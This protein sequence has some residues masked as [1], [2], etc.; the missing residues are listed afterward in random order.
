VNNKSSSDIW[1]ISKG[2]FSDVNFNKIPGIHIKGPVMEYDIS[3]FGKYML[4]P[5]PVYIE[6]RLVGCRVDFIPKISER[7]KKKIKKILPKKVHFII[8]ENAVP[9]EL[10]ISERKNDYPLV[11]E[12]SL[13]LY[14]DQIDESLLAF[15]ITI[16]RL[17]RLNPK[18]ISD[19]TGICEDFGGSRSF[20]KITGNIREKIDYIKN[21]LHKNVGVILERAYISNGLFEMRGYDFKSFNPLTSYKMIKFFAKGKIRVCVFNSSGEIDCWVD[22]IELFYF[23]HMLQH[24]LQKDVKFKNALDMCINGEALPLRIFFNKKFLVDYSEK[25]LPEAYKDTF[26]FFS[27]KS[28]YKAAV[29][30]SLKN[31]QY[32]IAFN[33]ISKS[34]SGNGKIVTS[35]SVMH[36]VKALEPIKKILPDLYSNIN[37]KAYVSEAGK[38][39]LLDSISGCQQHE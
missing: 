35:V 20:L 10:L 11:K 5:S 17:S 1:V 33:C 24:S 12:P 2:R 15:D 30:D 29:V 14:F 37:K 8:K 18:L 4:N 31:L 21:F 27:M 9:Y 6:K 25:N 23:M 26:D 13:S 38:Y 36:N 32:S 3:D 39:Y 22:N 16:R 34:D 19:I 7:I 28:E